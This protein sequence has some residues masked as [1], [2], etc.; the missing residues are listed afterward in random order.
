MINYFDFQEELVKIRRHFHKYPEIAFN[1]FET[2]KFIKSYMKKEGYILSDILPTGCI[3]VLNLNKSYPTVAV[4]AEMDAVPIYEKTGLEFS[5]KNKCAMHA[6]GHDANMAVALVL[7]KILVLTK[8]NLNCNIKF[9]FEPAEEIGEGAEVVINSGGLTNVDSFIMF[10]FSNKQSYGVEVNKDIATAAIGRLNIKFY[11]V[12]THWAALKKGTDALMAACKMVVETEKINTDYKSVYPFCV[13]IGKMQSGTSVNVVADYAEINGNIRTCSMEDYENI[14]KIIF[15]TVKKIENTTGVKT[16]IEISQ[17]P[18]TPIINDKNMVKK[19]CKVGKYV[20]G[21]NFF[22]T[23][24][25]YLAGDNACLYFEKVPG[26][27]MV[28]RAKYINDFP[29]HNPKFELNEEYFYKSVEMLHKYI[30]SLY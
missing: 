26:I 15:D 4:R 17:K 29:L 22:L 2:T 28:F 18:I 10:H 27:F 5:S 6:C 14:S 25:L 12:S 16:A 8:E 19:A 3:A 13:G 20:F 9:I 11:G 24:K 30:V 23:D 21:D 7:A 1:E